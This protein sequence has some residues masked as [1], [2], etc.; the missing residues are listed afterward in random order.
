VWRAAK[1]G[2]GGRAKGKGQSWQ[3]WQARTAKKG[4][5]WQGKGACVVRG[6]LTR[7]GASFLFSLAFCGCRNYFPSAFPLLL[8]P[9]QYLLLSLFIF[10]FNQG[11]QRNKFKK[12]KS[13]S[14]D[15]PDIKTSK[16]ESATANKKS[17]TLLFLF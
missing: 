16:G 11:T 13:R 1:E 17:L 10:I 3:K 9:T 2:E 7:T 8:L 15:L 14:P 4:K 6:T 12:S 5:E